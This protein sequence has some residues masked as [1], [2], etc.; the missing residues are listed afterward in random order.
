MVAILLFLAITFSPF[1]ATRAQAAAS[2]PVG[3]ASGPSAGLAPGPSAGLAP[4]PSAGLAPGPSGPDCTTLLLGMADCL[5]YVQ[6]GSNLTKPDKPCCPE[7]KSL[8][9]NSPICLCELL[10]NSDTSGFQIDINRATK[11]PSVCKVDT[12][13]P[14]TCALLG[15]PVGVPT[16]SEGP[17]PSSGLSPAGSSPG[18]NSGNRASSATTASIVAVLVGFAI[19]FSSTI[20]F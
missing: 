5:S 12:P 8:V 1:Q 9:D 16:S 19:T 3:L 4:G 17:S 11:L 10:A 7:L 14:S 18:K 13:P 20:F 15:I 6:L 2:G